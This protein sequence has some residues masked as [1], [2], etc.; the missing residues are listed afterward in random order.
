MYA[1]IKTGSKQYRV[2]SGDFI[3][4]ELLPQNDSNTVSFEDVLLIGAEGKVQVGNPV[5][6]GAVVKGELLGEVKD[7]KLIIFKY[8]KRKHSQVKKGHRQKLSRVKI[9]SIHG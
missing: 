3:D 4:V 7:E 6:Q 2:K 5:I 1:I 8:R 9:T